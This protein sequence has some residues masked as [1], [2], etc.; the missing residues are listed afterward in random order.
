M[1]NFR[2]HL[3]S[4]IAVFLAIGLGILV[5]STVVDQ[6]IVDRL[7]REIEEAKNE[8]G[9]LRDQIDRLQADLR[10]ADDYIAQ[11]APYA[12]DGR[13]D[14]VPVALLAE[15]GIDG[16][17]VEAIVEM[18]RD[19]GAEPAVIRLEERWRLDDPDD[20]AALREA[21]DGSGSPER[22]REA[23]FD[24]LAA[25][26]VEAPAPP[27][28]GEPVT[29]ALVRLADA[30]FVEVDGDLDVG[31]FPPRPAR[32]VVVTGTDSD[33]L[34]V[35][36]GA[37]SAALAR[38]LVAADVPTVAG[39]VYVASDEPDAPARGATLADVRGDGDLSSAV[40]TVDDLD[41]VPG[42]VATVIALEDLVTG[43]V[44]HYGHGEGADEAIPRA[45]P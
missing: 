41:A 4:L 44:G 6:A 21:V 8:N 14:G 22:V 30:G 40:S 39:E 38:A 15:A 24:A 5:G 26:L 20:V 28:E 27:A 13:L 1:V 32:A 10:R 29:D 35:D 33:L 36:G 9:D 37:L 42:R 7:D 12:V 25:R 16:D 34:D 3:V 11:S 43:R 17:D 31:A 2:F 23:A 45:A 18:L 19:A